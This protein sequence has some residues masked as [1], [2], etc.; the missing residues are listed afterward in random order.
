MY[1]IT[2]FENWV[3]RLAHGNRGWG[4][5]RSSCVFGAGSENPD[6]TQN[7]DPLAQAYADRAFPCRRRAPNHVLPSCMVVSMVEPFGNHLGDIVL[8]LGFCLG[9]HFY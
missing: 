5:P 2:F 9:M 7:L 3:K 8:R 4:A 6:D 1:L